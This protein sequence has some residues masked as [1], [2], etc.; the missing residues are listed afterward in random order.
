MATGPVMHLSAEDS[1]DP[2]TGVR[3]PVING[4]CKMLRHQIPAFAEYGGR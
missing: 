1:P 3:G 4:G 2:K